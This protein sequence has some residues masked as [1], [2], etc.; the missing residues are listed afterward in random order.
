MKRK[1]MSKAEILMNLYETKKL[2]KKAVSAPFTGMSVLCNH[3]LWKKEHMSQTK[4]T[5]YNQLIAEYEEKLEEGTVTREELEERLWN[6]AEFDIKNYSMSSEDIEKA[7]Q[8][9]NF[10]NQL[11]KIQIESFN[12]INEMSTRHLV[13][14]FNVLMDMG[15]GKVRLTRVKDGLKE[16]LDHM[17]EKDVMEMRRELFD[18]FGIYIEM[19]N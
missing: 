17:K 16:Y 2:Q 7:T 18:R 14:H 5:E 1:Q 11:A 8:K 15:Y 4:I 19:P 6:K 12:I 10:I 3:V 13:I 9:K